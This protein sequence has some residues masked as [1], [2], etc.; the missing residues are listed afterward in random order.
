MIKQ[1]LPSTVP[2]WLK[3]LPLVCFLILSLAIGYGIVIYNETMDNKTKGFEQSKQ[4]ALDQTALVS[5]DEVDRYH[6]E[7]FYHVVTGTTED[8]ERGFAFVPQGDEK[9]PVRLLLEKNIMNEEEMM[10]QWMN[11]CSSCSFISLNMGVNGDTYLWEIK[12]IDDQD[13]YVF[14]YYN[15][16][17]GEKFGNYRLRQSLY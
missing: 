1:Y 3:W 5:T 6:G 13:R 16:M 2:K 10:D 4:E 17:N 9:K 11:T 12:Y 14:D 15:V 7:K 8:G